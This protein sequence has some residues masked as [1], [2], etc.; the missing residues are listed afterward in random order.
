M[1]RDWI[2]T[3]EKYRQQSLSPVAVTIQAARAAFG[4]DWKKG[5]LEHFGRW[6]IILDD[7]NQWEKFGC[8]LWVID[9]IEKLLKAMRPSD[10]ARLFEIEAALKAIPQRPGFIGKERH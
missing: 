9:D 1:G 4:P 5:A 8:P 3:D 6:E 10:T 2:I 7:V